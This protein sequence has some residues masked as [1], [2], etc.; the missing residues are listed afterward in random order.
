M[1]HATGWLG[2]EGSPQVGCGIVHVAEDYLVPI[3]DEQIRRSTVVCLAVI[4]Q[5]LDI[6]PTWLGQKCQTKEIKETVLVVLY[7]KRGFN[8][9]L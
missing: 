3:V 7:Q 8:P 5:E 4:Y 1:S 2:D 6:T 9:N